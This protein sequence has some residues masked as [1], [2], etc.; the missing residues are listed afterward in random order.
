MKWLFQSTAIIL[1]GILNNSQDLTVYIPL[2]KQ[3]TLINTVGS[4]FLS[5]TVPEK[6]RNTVPAPF[7]CLFVWLGFFFLYPFCFFCGLRDPVPPSPVQ[8]MLGSVQLK[9][10]GM[11]VEFLGMRGDPISSICMALAQNQAAGCRFLC[12]E[13]MEAILCLLESGPMFGLWLAFPRS[14]QTDILRCGLTWVR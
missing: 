14:R 1:T 11:T 10:L 6:T 8:H 7:F 3:L 9:H 2:L 12:E 4:R 13:K 5:L